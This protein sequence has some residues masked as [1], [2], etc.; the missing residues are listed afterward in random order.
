MQ[1]YHNVQYWL[2]QLSIRFYFA[3]G[4]LLLEFYEEITIKFFATLAGRPGLKVLKKK[5]SQEHCF[6]SILLNY[7][8]S[9]IKLFFDKTNNL[10]K[11][12]TILK[13]PCAKRCK[14]LYC[15]GKTTNSYKLIV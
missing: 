9:T 12:S 3:Y 10:S 14:K 6:D 7:W 2:I 5:G 15:S 13:I 4:S 11:A 1:L 8:I